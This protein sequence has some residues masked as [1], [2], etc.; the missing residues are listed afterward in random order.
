MTAIPPL[1]GL[2]GLVRN[3]RDREAGTPARTGS[4]QACELCA[5]PL[6]AEHRHLLEVTDQRI[7]CSCQACGVL[8]DRKAAAGGRYRS[9]P[10]TRRRLP[11]LRIDDV[12]WAGLGVPVRLVF[13]VR[14]EPGG[15]AEPART[16]AAP[17]GLPPAAAPVTAHYPS[18]LGVVTTPVDD[19]AWDRVVRANP[20]LAELDTEVTA[21]L[22][23]RGL[24]EHWVVGLDDC[25]R[26]TARVRHQWSG[27]TGG[28]EVW[29]VIEEFFTE[30]RDGGRPTSGSASRT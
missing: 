12:L 20:V 27:M 28:D 24:D 18:P 21:L 3:E 7:R 8:F 26:L 19:E 17:H 30:L 15:G 29:H 1:T 4:T 13:F 10:R 22:T 25:Y 2:R 11:D 16:R 23:H 9:V 5:E 6:P 14:H